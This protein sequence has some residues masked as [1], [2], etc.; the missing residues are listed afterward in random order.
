MKEELV[1]KLHQT[2]PLLFP[3]KTW[4]ECG[5]GWFNLINTLCHNIQSH[6][7]NSKRRY[8]WAIEHN[9]KLAEDPSYAA[10]DREPRKVNEPAAQVEVQQI[11]EKFGG[12]RFYVNHGDDV[13]YGMTHFSENLSYQL[14]EEC[15]NQGTRREG[16]WIRT[17]CDQHHVKKSLGAD[18]TEL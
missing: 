2:Y 13:V 7:D 11:K 16:G 5:D 8:D 12:L 14:C 10:F 1:N 17:L 15:G 6:I 4:P 18:N 3:R 9:R